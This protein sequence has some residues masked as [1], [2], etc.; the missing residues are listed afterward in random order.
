M[1]DFE[2]ATSPAPRTPAVLW[3]AGGLALGLT[4]G[5]LMGRP[6]R[7]S[8]D[9]VAGRK[10]LSTGARAALAV[11][12]ELGLAIA[13]RAISDAGGAEEVPTGDSATTT[14]PQTTPRPPSAAEMAINAAA[15]HFPGLHP[16]ISRA[17]RIFS[18]LWDQR[19]IG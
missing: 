8:G 13:V 16:G 11:A 2:P 14:L 19:K 10:G 1:T 7:K 5:V 9:A 4:A 12:G 6:L 15:K 18:S 3:I 17:A